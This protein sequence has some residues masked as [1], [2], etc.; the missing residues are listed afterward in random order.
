MTAVFDH[1][2]STGSARLVLLVIADRAGDDGAGCW[3]GKESIAHMARVSR[4]TVTEAIKALEALGELEVDRRPG[5]TSQYRVVLPGVGTRPDSGRPPGRIPADQ[6]A[7]PAGIRPTV[8]QT[9]GRPVGQTGGRDTSLDTSIALG[10]AP[11]DKPEPTAV[12]RALI[13]EAKARA[14]EADALSPLRRSR[15]G[16]PK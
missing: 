12:G 8:G 1:S 10:P 11:V 6:P 9:G 3:R 2:E 13:A 16:D 5:A 7:D 14:R 15:G 4:T